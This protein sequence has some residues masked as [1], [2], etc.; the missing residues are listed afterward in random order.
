MPDWAAY[1][2]DIFRENGF[3]VPTPALFPE[4]QRII[5]IIIIIIVVVVVVV[6][7]VIIIIKKL[8]WSGGPVLVVGVR[9]AEV[10]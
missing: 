1:A 3:V 5:I 6:V 7:I 8:G 9:L 4:Y 2:A 10:V